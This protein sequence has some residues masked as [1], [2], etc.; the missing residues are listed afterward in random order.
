MINNEFKD[1]IIKLEIKH[2][3]IDEIN[4]FLYYLKQLYLSL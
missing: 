1:D 4:N 3:F 2:C